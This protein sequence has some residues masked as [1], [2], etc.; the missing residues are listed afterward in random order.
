MIYLHINVYSSTCLIYVYVWQNE[1][2]ILYLNLL[3]MCKSFQTLCLLKLSNVLLDCVYLSEPSSTDFCLPTGM[4]IGAQIKF[5]NISQM[6]L[7]IAWSVVFILSYLL[8]L[9]LLR[10]YKHGTPSVDWIHWS[11]KL[12]RYPLPEQFMII[13]H[14]KRQSNISTL[15]LRKVIHESN[16]K[17]HQL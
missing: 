8:S 6:D 17:G 7:F 2:V 9:N 3:E 1:W 16:K 4:V 14:T 15:T 12:A 13:Y 5:N 11:G 10:G